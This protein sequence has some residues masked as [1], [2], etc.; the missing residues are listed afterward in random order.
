MKKTNNQGFSLVELIIVIAIMAVLI[1]VLAP[2]FIKYVERGRTQRDASA[3]E[4]LRNA[5]EIALSEEPVYT[6]V[7]GVVTTTAPANITINTAGVVTIPTTLSTIETEVSE[8]LVLDL[9]FSSAT[10]TAAG[11]HLVISR[12]ANG[13]FNVNAVV[14]QPV[15]P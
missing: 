11:A 14:G 9:N 7:I 6:Q 12:T 15:T 5:V 8:T 13:T 4:E 10:Y 3:V 2:Q 1:G